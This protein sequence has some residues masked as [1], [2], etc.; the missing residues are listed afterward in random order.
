VSTRLSTAGHGCV[1][2]SNE[3]WREGTRCR[4]ARARKTHPTLA[5]T[6]LLLIRSRRPATATHYR[7]RLHPERQPRACVRE[8]LLRGESHHTNLPGVSCGIFQ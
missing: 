3:T 6:T 2:A 8:R 1:Y 4:R 7:N 5:A